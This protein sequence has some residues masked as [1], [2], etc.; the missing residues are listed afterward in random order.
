MKLHLLPSSYV[1]I[2]H[3]M[4]PAEKAAERCLWIKDIAGGFGLILF[5]VAAFVMASDI[6]HFHMP[7]IHFAL[8]SAN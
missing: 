1:E 5:F 8:S 4:T 3:S 6:A 7:S 2:W